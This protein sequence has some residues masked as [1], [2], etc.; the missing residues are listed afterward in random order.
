MTKTIQYDSTGIN[1]EIKYSIESQ[2]ETGFTGKIVIMNT[3][4]VMITPWQLTFHF[5]G[6]QFI[7][8]LWNGTFKQQGQSVIINNADYN[9]EITPGKF[10]EVGFT[11]SFSGVNNKPNDF[12]LNGISPIMEFGF[13]EVVVAKPSFSESIF[14]PEVTVAGIT[15]KVAWGE[16]VEFQLIAGAEYTVEANTFKDEN[17][18][19]KPLIFPQI[20]LVEKDVIKTSNINYERKNINQAIDFNILYSIES[21]W[22]SGF[23]GKIVIEN[24]G[25]KIISPWQLNFHFPG[26]QK[27][28]SLWNGIYNQQGQLVTINNVD[29]NKDILPSK[30]VTVGFTATYSGVNSKP[31]DFTLNGI[32]PEVDYGYIEVTVEKP[33][34][35]EFIFLPKI[36]IDNVTKE[37]EWEQ[38]ATFK[39]QSGKEYIIE[40]NSYKSED[41]IY[42][43]TIEPLK[44]IVEKDNIKQSNIIYNQSKVNPNIF[45]GYFPSWKDRW[46]SVGQATDL[47]NLPSYVNRVIL[48]F[49]KPDMVYTGNY[50]ISQTGLEFPYGGNILK[51]A[52]DYL[53]QKNPETKILVSVG[54]ATYV[55]W[56]A[57]NAKGIA[58]LVRDFH[59]DGVDIDYEPLIDWGCKPDSAGIVHC[60]TD[61]QYISLIEAIRVELPRPYLISA[62][63][64]SVGAYGEGLWK[65]APPAN[66]TSTGMMLEV[67]KKA[68]DK[69]DI[70]NVQGY[71]AGPTFSPL[72]A[73]EAYNYCFKGSIAMGAMVPPEDWSTGRWTIDKIDEVGDY[74][75][76]NNLGG[77][78]LWDLYRK[79]EI[80]DSQTM[81][82]AIAKVLGFPNYNDP[83]FPLHSAV[84]NDSIDSKY[85]IPK[86]PKLVCKKYPINTSYDII[87]LTEV[88]INATSCK[89]YQNG[90]S[91]NCIAL[92]D[93]TPKAGT[94][95][96]NIYYNPKGIYT[97]RVE[98]INKYGSIFSEY[99]LVNVD[100]DS[101]V[102]CNPTK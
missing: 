86:K 17:Y 66:L 19:Y 48:A 54:G 14:K 94:I 88:G 76:K 36:T 32:G 78:M 37:I 56:G 10:V 6:N 31:T 42:I 11:A 46:S 72:Q 41:Y 57:F 21:Q 81:S 63:P 18:I 97:Y 30:N 58:R 27:I 92:E 91:I 53:K 75:N 49:V 98:L 22:N 95:V 51:E 45:C 83:L 5:P 16:K 44:I 34:F 1:F 90:L 60:V 73:T 93:K 65:D 20:I 62:A 25:D 35:S 43:P 47:G 13:I 7:T 50:D 102:T 87:V 67:I 55:N 2:W 101:S 28:S 71:N 100:E 52:I 64:F 12:T 33:S 24:I 29:Y 40:A 39:L 9:K 68:G 99:L 74:I 59:L 61:D 38:S 85:L 26:N 15:Q 77:M 4:K 82:S 69:I 89:L 8:S 96:F 79:T 70:L 84:S 3:G 23:T 80:A